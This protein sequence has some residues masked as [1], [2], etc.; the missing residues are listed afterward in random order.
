MAD[1]KKL[2]YRSQE[3]LDTYGID[4]VTSVEVK[5]IDTHRSFVQTKNEKHIHYDK[6]LIA[7]GGAPRRIPVEGANAKNVH[8]LRDF[9]DVNALKENC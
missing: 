7:T 2:Q 9:A 8:T 1:A 5:E 3:F 4:V 6:L